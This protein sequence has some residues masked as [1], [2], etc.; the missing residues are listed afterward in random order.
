MTI[1][2]WRKP[3][4]GYNCNT[5]MVLYPDVDL[6]ISSVAWIVSC[7][8]VYFCYII[9]RYKKFAFNCWIHG[10]TS[11]WIYFCFPSQTARLTWPTWGPPGSCRPQVGPMLAPWTLLSGLTYWWHVGHYTCRN[12]AGDATYGC[13][14]KYRKCHDNFFIWVFLS[15]SD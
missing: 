8:R 3:I 13:G 11:V 6:I 12:F 9:V 5:P 2:S 4:D 15:L 7:Y 10:I 1:S 14:F